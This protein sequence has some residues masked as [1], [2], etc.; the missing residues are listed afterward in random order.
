MEYYFYKKDSKSKGINYESLV[1]CTLAAMNIIYSGYWLLFNIS[2][3]TLWYMSYEYFYVTILSLLGLLKWVT[4]IIWFIVILKE[5]LDNY[6]TLIVFILGSTFL[7]F[8]IYFNFLLLTLLGN[9]FSIYEAFTYPNLIEIGTDLLITATVIVLLANK[10][11]SE[12]YK[13]MVPMKIMRY[14]NPYP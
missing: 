2:N 8:F 12:P 9:G 4:K 10:S 7:L 14:F 1:I 3:L 5:R 13:T 6:I 11:K